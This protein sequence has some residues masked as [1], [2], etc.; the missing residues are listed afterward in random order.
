MI[1]KEIEPVVVHTTEVRE[2]DS[3]VWWIGGLVAVA[4]IVAIVFFVTRQPQATPTDLINATEQGRLTGQLE[5][6]Q[7]VG[8]SAQSAA[9]SAADR[10]Q[11]SADRAAD[12]ASKA[13]SQPAPAPTIINIPA[14]S[15]PA[16]P[17]PQ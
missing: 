4:A 2:N 11:A 14:P 12:T 7:S 17:A 15:A 1:I 10:A 8:S 13:S 5:A 9:E 3:A 6:S 16:A